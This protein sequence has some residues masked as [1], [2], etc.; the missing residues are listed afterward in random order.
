MIWSVFFPPGFNWTDRHNV[1]PLIKCVTCSLLFW[2]S[3]RTSHFLQRL[4]AQFWGRLLTASAPNAPVLRGARAEARGRATDDG[5]A[6]KTCSE[7]KPLVALRTR[8]YAT[9][10]FHPLQCTKMKRRVVI[11]ISSVCCSAALLLSSVWCDWM[12]FF[13]SNI[14]KTCFER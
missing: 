3:P 2:K 6:V 12:N 8:R 4:Y 13:H 7:T 11:F 1:Q 9:Q 14:L 5:V 10:R